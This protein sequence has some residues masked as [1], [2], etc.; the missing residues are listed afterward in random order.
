MTYDTRTIDQKVRDMFSP[1]SIAPPTQRTERPS[2]DVYF[3]EQ[4]IHVSSRSTCPRAAVGCVMVQDKFALVSGFNGSVRGAPHCTEVG[5]LMESNHCIR[6]LHAEQN[7]IIQAA[8]TGVSLLGATCYVTHHP[9]ALC[10][11]MLINVGIIRV[12]YLN[13][14]PPADGGEFLRQAGI[15]VERLE[16]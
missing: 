13:M 11:N 9:C 14:Y 16:L 10:A 7:A 6:S 8:R 3:M 4:A 12:V 15:V 5:C 2:W 1:T